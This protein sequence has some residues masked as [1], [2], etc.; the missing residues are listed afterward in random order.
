MTRSL[1]QFLTSANRLRPDPAPHVTRGMRRSL[2]ESV[3]ELPIKSPRDNWE[4]MQVGDVTHIERTFDLAPNEVKML[5]CDIIDA[6]EELSHTVKI[7][8]DGGRVTVRSTTHEHGEPT[9]RDR[10]IA[11]HIDTSYDEMRRTYR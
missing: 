5:V 4:T 3:G 2:L 8:I 10:E 11:R 6:Q 9:E 7:I 1:Q